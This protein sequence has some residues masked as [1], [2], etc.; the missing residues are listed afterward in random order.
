MGGNAC[1]NVRAS[2]SDTHSRSASSADSMDASKREN[3]P[4]AMLNA[5]DDILVWTCKQ[6]PASELLHD[7]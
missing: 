7:T 3:N 6:S 1:S 5:M 4:S 2:G